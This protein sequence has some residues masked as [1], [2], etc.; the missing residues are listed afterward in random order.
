[1][2]KIINLYTL[3]IRLYPIC[4]PYVLFLWRGARRTENEEAAVR[5]LR[6][7]A[8]LLA[9]K[10]MAAVGQE[11]LT[12]ALELAP[13]LLGEEMSYVTYIELHAI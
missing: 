9:S 8:A 1:M 13:W 3:Y 10:A 12:A 5:C 7:L 4:D 2:F 11:Q 6:L